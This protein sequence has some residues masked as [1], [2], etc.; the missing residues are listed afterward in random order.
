[1]NGQSKSTEFHGRRRRGED[2]GGRGGYE[3]FL[4]RCDT[5]RDS[6]S[7]KVEIQRSTKTSSKKLPN[8]TV[9]DVLYKIVSTSLTDHNWIDMSI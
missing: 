5:E 7:F 2:L 4:T 8:S 6:T 3:V 9:V 1:M